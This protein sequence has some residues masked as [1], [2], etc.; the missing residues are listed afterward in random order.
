MT[1]RELSQRP[2]SKQASSCSAPEHA[3]DERA[4]T[5]EETSPGTLP[6][7]GETEPG[8]LG[9]QP[10]APTGPRTVQFSG[11]LPPGVIPAASHETST[12]PEPLSE[13]PPAQTRSS[14]AVEYTP[15]PTVM[16]PPELLGLPPDPPSTLASPHTEAAPTPPGSASS[17]RW[18]VLLLLLLVLAGVAALMSG[19]DEESSTPQSRAEAESQEKSPEQL[20]RERREE[21][22]EQEKAEAEAQAQRERERAQQKASAWGVSLTEARVD[23]PQALKRLLAGPGASLQWLDIYGQLQAEAIGPYVFLDLQVSSGYEGFTLRGILTDIDAK[24]FGFQGSFSTQVSRIAGGQNC[25]RG[26]GNYRFVVYP[27]AP[28][29]RMVQMDNP[30]DGVVDYLDLHWTP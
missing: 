21:H 5:P 28:M 14:A 9:A 18:K 6:H 12:Q 19:G 13:L 8:T 26:L 29:W 20:E 15:T 10:R 25:Q 4:S 1:A 11:S 3:P 23:D 16:A 7:S 30:C 24:G 17:S 22:L 2:D 27:G